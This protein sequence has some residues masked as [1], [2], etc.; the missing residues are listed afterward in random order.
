[1]VGVSLGVVGVPARGGQAL[2]VL[3]HHGVA[4]VFPGTPL[5]ALGAGSCKIMG[6]CWRLVVKTITKKA[7]DT[8]CSS[9]THHRQG[10]TDTQREGACAGTHRHT[11]RGIVGR[12]TQTHNVRGRGRYVQH[13]HKDR[14]QP[15]DPIFG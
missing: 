5:S 1:M 3:G 7:V 2:D 13:A 4:V 15:S 6:S 8:A 12:N 14:P 11:T 9:S 10:D